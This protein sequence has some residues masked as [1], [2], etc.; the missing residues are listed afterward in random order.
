MARRRAV[1][2]HS[3]FAVL[4]RRNSAIARRILLAVL[5]AL[6][7]IVADPM[8][9]GV[10]QTPAVPIELTQPQAIEQQGRSR[11]E[12]GDFAAAAIAFR[13][14]AQAYRIQN[15][16]LREALSLSNLSLTYQRLG[17]LPPAAAAIAQSL[18]LL[19]GA[20]GEQRSALAQALDI[21]GRLQLGQGQFEAA[22]ATWQ[23]SADLYAQ[24]GDRSQV[25]QSQINQ[26]QALQALGLYRRAIATLNA[27]LGIPPTIAAADLENLLS[28][29]PAS[30]TS[31]AALQSLGEALRAS[32]DLPQ[33]RLVLQRSLVQAES[34]QQ[35]GAIAA[36]QFRLAN[37][38]RAEAIAFLSRN[39]QTLA[40]AVDLI[41][42]SQNG[43]TFIN[44]TD[45]ALE[46]ERQAD[47]ALNLYQQAGAIATETQTQAQLN[48]LSL[49]VELQRW[50]AVRSRLPQVQ[51]QIES[52][53]IDHSA[54]YARIN[55]A[56]TIA[57]ASQFAESDLGVAAR[58]LVAQ[59]LSDTI[60]QAGSLGDAR[61]EAYAMGALGS[62]Y[63]QNQ[64]QAIAQDLT[65]QALVLSQSNGAADI[66][67]RWQWQLGRLLNAQGQKTAAIAAYREA[68]TTLQSLRRDL[69][70]INPD[71][72]FS[73][74]ETIEPIHR[75]LV[76]LL[77]EADGN[78]AP[79][80][81]NLAAAREVIES[82]QLAE[83]DNFFREACLNAN[84]TNI[85][86]VDRSAAIFYPIILPTQLAVVVSLPQIDSPDRTLIYY[87]TPKSESEVE[88]AANLLLNSSKQGSD[89]RYERPAQ[90][91]YD[92]LIR[93]AKAQLEAN[94]VKTLVF[95]LDGVLRNAPIAALND[96][97]RFLVQQYSLAVTPGLQLLAARPL[98]QARLSALVAG[99]SEARGGEPALS[100]VENEVQEI[101]AEIPNS[102]I[103]L[104]SEF[105]SSNLQTAI[106][107]VPF[108]IIHLATHGNFSSQLEQTYILTWDGRL[109]INQ[110]RSLLQAT[111][112]NQGEPL[113]LLVLSACETAAGDDRAA[114]GLAGMAV[115]AGARSTIA[116]LWQV[117]D[118]S[119]AALMQ[120]FY[121]ELIQPGITKAEALSQAQRSLLENPDYRHPFYWS[122]YILVGNWQ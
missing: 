115:R 57:N 53:P 3:V 37:V 87:A 31:I 54:L 119:S 90:Q 82:L 58:V 73:F 9:I 63:E 78:T 104:N 25:N 61:A 19:E 52:L 108:P 49:L 46:F 86:R 12:A 44:R 20:T 114:L 33:A 100:S 93:P 45:V 99:L 113:E 98:A 83:L 28:D 2:L 89:N 81:E 101:E 26:A 88:Q 23:R 65:E 121:D 5:T 27:V 18:E 32:G 70:A 11:Y 22:L 107:A 84:A 76:A 40:A 80:S 92:W 15:D 6:L 55:F 77:L 118:A 97:D 51:Q 42:Q 66:A 103:L 47:V 36:A 35:P 39:N 17:Q 43:Q 7:C 56:Q 71:E 64:Q 30:P 116:T 120:R 94:Q 109:N 16:S 79:K 68:V 122:P 14:A 62:V 74:R 67:Y 59:L 72:Q 106:Q 50:T 96:G 60:Q 69:V 10:A 91:L 1:F 112:F 34:L 29:L 95:V 105:T 13:Q 75:E 111:N 117:N 21:Q 102:E 110:F 4:A 8:A 38:T 48:Q 41:R 24:L 85:D